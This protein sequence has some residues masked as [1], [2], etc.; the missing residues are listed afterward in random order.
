MNLKSQAYSR[1]IF[2]IWH[3][4][5]SAAWG[6]YFSV[7]PMDLF[8]HHFRDFF[9][10]RA[11]P[12]MRYEFDLADKPLHLA[13]RSKVKNWQPPLPNPYGG[14][15][16]TERQAN[17]AWYSPHYALRNQPPTSVQPESTKTQD[18]WDLLEDAKWGDYNSFE[19]YSYPWAQRYITTAWSEPHEIPIRLEK[20]IT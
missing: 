13:D 1:A 7:V 19:V 6:N 15:Y 17:D 12:K 8:F 9:P 2:K 16:L 3:S 20:R 18:R 4:P 10:Y 14:M 11:S 5:R